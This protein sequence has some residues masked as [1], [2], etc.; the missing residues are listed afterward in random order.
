MTLSPFDEFMAQLRAGDW[1]NRLDELGEALTAR[2]RVKD[3]VAAAAITV[4]SRVMVE[5]TSKPAYM[6]LAQGEVTGFTRSGKCQVTFTNDADGYPLPTSK[7][8]W[9]YP[10][11]MLIPLDG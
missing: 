1:D 2:R 6:R 7:R 10:A 3:A 8:K 9:Q 11:S 5:P 4:G